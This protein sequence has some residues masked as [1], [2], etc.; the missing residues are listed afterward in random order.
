M[1]AVDPS[2]VFREGAEH[3]RAGR[4][5]DARVVLAHA[6]TLAPHAVE[7]WNLYGA[8]LARLGELA[9]A[10][11]AFERA[12]ALE[13]RAPQAWLNL[14][15]ARAGI[16]EYD[17]AALDFERAL[18]A[19]PHFLPARVS[20]G[21]LR[22]KQQRPAEALELFEQARAAEPGFPRIEHNRGAALQALGQWEPAIAAYRE[23]LR[24]EPTDLN[25]L[26][27]LSIVLLKAGQPEAAL[28]VCARCLALSPAN[29]KP[30]A[31]RAAALIELGRLDEAR[32]LL[33]FER[34]LFRQRI[35]TPA[36][37]A[38]VTAFNA[39]LAAHVLAHPTLRYEPPDKATR[40]GYQSG[41]LLVEPKGAMAG[42]EAA[43]R[44][45]VPAF[46]SRAR[47][48]LPAH[49]W[50]V[51]LPAR[52]QLASWAVVLKAQGQQGP[53]FHPDGYI[54]GVYYLQLP[55][56]VKSAAD[57]SGCIEFGRTNEAIGGRA[58]PL[59]EV[60]RPEEGLLLL[61]PSYF[62]HRTLPF[63]GPEP[64]ICVAFD[65]LPR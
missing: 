56:V 44:A 46:M 52:W 35:E 7:A 33:D 41:E 2:T 11:P 18:H 20:L 37:H 43:I 8:T 21:S 10:V 12:T 51:G 19:D 40:G 24:R 36:G 1:S 47:A 65:V 6:V 48:Q 57:D 3:F 58:P 45:A 22:L 30:L 13:P 14:G 16:G 5:L 29:R 63:D 31:Y 61:F 39:A 50:V 64:R 26:N 49:P 62:Y 59:L 25:S 4:L 17:R 55:S 15:N 23:A 54:S 28:E 34:L 60:V 32:E 38:S 27:D 53:H 42:L 9:A